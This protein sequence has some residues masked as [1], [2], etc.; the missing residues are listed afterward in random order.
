[1]SKRYGLAPGARWRHWDEE[2]EAVVYIEARFETHLLGEASVFLLESLSA[3]GQ[4]MDEQAL[5]QALLYGL[6]DIVAETAQEMQQEQQVREAQIR[7]LIHQ[8]LSLG[9]IAEQT[10]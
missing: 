2:D 10:C 6:P 1:M 7:T 8:L 5:S 4:P 3:A 9:V